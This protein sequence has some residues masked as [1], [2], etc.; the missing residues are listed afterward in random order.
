[1]LKDKGFYISSKKIDAA[2]VYAI[3]K[4]NNASTFYVSAYNGIITGSFSD[5]LVESAVLQLQNDINL[6]SNSAFNKIYKT[7]GKNNTANLYINF[8]AIPKFIS[9]VFRNPKDIPSVFKSNNA[10]WAELDVE[11]KSKE[12]EMNG[13]IAG[14]KNSLI[15]ELFSGMKPGKSTINRIFPAN[16]KIYMSY[17]IPSAD[18]LKKRFHSYLKKSGNNI[19]YDRT[20]NNLRKK[21]KINPDDELFSIMDN[22]MALVF[23]DI[24]QNDPN[25]NSFLVIKTKGQSFSLDRITKALKSAGLKTTPVDIYK[26]D[27]ETSFPV[28]RGMPEGMISAVM[29]W[30]FPVIPDKYFTFYD[31]YLIF[32]N[33]I[34][35]I[36]N[37]LYSNVLK[38]TLP[39]KKYFTDFKEKFSIKENFFIYSEIPVLPMYLKKIFKPDYLALSKVQK[40]ELE[41]FYAGGLQITTTGG[42]LYAN[43][44]ANYLPSRENEPQTIWQSLLDS[45]VINKPVLVK[46]HYTNEKELMVQDAKFNL[47][48]INNSGRLLWKKPLD[49]KILGTIQQ[50]DYYKNSKLQYIFNTKNKIYLLD[51]NGNNVDKYPLS[52]PV[53]ATN[54]IAVMDYDKNK[55]YRLFLATEDRKVRLY[56]K[57]GNT[58]SGW[59]F[60]KTEGTVKQPVQ[61][62]RSNSKDY[63]VFSDN[64]KIYILNRRGE[65][66]VKP[67]KHISAASN[68][69]FFIKGVNTS[70]C[71]LITTSPD[72]QLIFIAIP[73]GKVRVQELINKTGE[74]AFS[75]FEQYGKSRFVYLQPD[76]FEIFDEKGRQAGSK[77]FSNKMSLTID[78]YRFSAN[79]IK[80]GIREKD[81]DLIYLI[82]SDGSIYKGFP[83]R[84]RSRFSIGFLKSPS[85]KFNLVV[86]GDNNYIYNYRV[87]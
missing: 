84:G 41:K 18:K 78:Q 86:G 5:L 23:T 8:A 13:F 28:Y 46:N 77:S 63:I 1:N 4:G 56:D 15:N 54:G 49:G 40:K 66:R 69:R 53:K 68:C 43:L 3:K 20:I 35:S 22:E 14:E 55:D 80:L 12:I 76:K 83:L 34:K 36:H 29:G 60:N 39:N 82:N 16:T 62:F 45:T 7:S 33:N 6:F 42:L 50:I 74:F 24:N 75:Y 81:G 44:Y 25:V 72:A 47:Y 38:Q 37:F 58:I 48:L 70:E 64:H 19:S 57:R 21:Y 30:F 26:I 79:D 59:E 11:I 32:A 71:K 51:R 31:N 52:L 67:G 65:E 85:T 27:S 2:T 10:L 73:S 87:E 17:K 61:H 9:V